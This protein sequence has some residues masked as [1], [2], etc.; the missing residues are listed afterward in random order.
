MRAVAS[1]KETY[2]ISLS[3]TS[4]R[5]ASWS[6]T[7]NVPAHHTA[8]VQQYHAGYEVGIIEHIMEYGNGGTSCISK[9]F[10]S[11]TG[12]FFNVRST[13]NDAYCYALVSKRA[14]PMLGSTCKNKI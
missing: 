9:R 6:Y 14:H 5:S 2:G 12:N 1:A 4:S 8:R 7:E 11:L 10:V 3:K 13:G